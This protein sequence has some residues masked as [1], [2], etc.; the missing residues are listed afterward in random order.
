[1]NLLLLARDAAREGQSHTIQVSAR[2][3]PANSVV[4]EFSDD[5][6]PIPADQLGA[7]FE[8]NFIGTQSGR[9]SGIEFSICRE[10]VRQHGGQISAESSP[11]GKT[12]FRVS[13]P[14]EV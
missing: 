4:I 11:A 2:R 7:I 12:I 5:G 13:L 9:G 8:P 10:I 3:G 1:M 14:G 6:R